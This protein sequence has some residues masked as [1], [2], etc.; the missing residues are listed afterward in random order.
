MLTMV[1]EALTAILWNRCAIDQERTLVLPHWVKAVAPLVFQ[2]PM[3]GRRIGGD[4]NE[5]LRFTLRIK[6]YPFGGRGA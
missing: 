4:D 3:P 1:S 2:T 6:E 5:V